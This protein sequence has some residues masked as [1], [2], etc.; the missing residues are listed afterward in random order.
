MNSIN[1]PA[2]A[3]LPAVMGSDKQAWRRLPKGVT[4][5]EAVLRGWILVEAVGVSNPRALILCQ[6]VTYYG[7]TKAGI[8]WEPVEF[9]NLSK[10]DL[11]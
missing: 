3:S 1:V 8:F 2:S 7:D 4:A 10:A 11:P 9:R 5:H 6:Q